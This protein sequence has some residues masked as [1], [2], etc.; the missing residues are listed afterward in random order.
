M[1]KTV[2]QRVLVVAATHSKNKVVDTLSLSCNTNITTNPSSQI[3]FRINLSTHLPHF[4]V[5]SFTEAVR[6]PHSRSQFDF[7]FL[8]S[9]SPASF[10]V[11]LGSRFCGPC[12]NNP[13]SI[14][15]LSYSPAFS[16]LLAQPPLSSV[17]D[18]SL[19]DY[20]GNLPK[21]IDDYPSQTTCL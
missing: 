10:S 8:F 20:S 19:T 21:A 13:L 5:S 12:K 3:F 7:S 6:N 11:R 9:P 17:T 18:S 4:L 16:G 1:I 14:A 2:V 15:I